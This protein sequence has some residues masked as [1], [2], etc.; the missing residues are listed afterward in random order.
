M[1][2][3]VIPSGTSE[4]TFVIEDGVARFMGSV[5]VVDVPSLNA[6]FPGFVMAGEDGPVP[7]RLHVFGFRGLVQA[8]GRG[9]LRRV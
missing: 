6:S 3:T 8:L 2:D 1:L 4:A 9:G 7:G 5:R